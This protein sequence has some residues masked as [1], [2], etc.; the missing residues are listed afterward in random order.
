MAGR[1]RYGAFWIPSQASEFRYLLMKKIL[2]GSIS[3]SQQSRLKELQCELGPEEAG[4]ILHELFGRKWAA[5]V[6][7]ALRRDSFQG[8]VKPLARRV[9]FRHAAKRPFQAVSYWLRDGVRAVKRCAQPTGLFVTV[10][11][12]D[13]VGKSTLLDGL[14]GQRH[15]FRRSVRFHWRPMLV[16]GRRRGGM[17]SPRTAPAGTRPGAPCWVWGSKY[18]TIGSAMFCC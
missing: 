11:G 5:K 8:L 4:R 2:K 17:V 15:L 7:E 6:P 1:R 12:P 9:R 14:E 16:G 3:A 10:L 18:R 13:G